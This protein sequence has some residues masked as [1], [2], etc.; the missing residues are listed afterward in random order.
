[1]A[2]HP[3]RNLGLKFA[4]LGLGALLWFTITGERVERKV[5]RVPI[6]YRNLPASLEITD[7]PDSVDIS[8]RGSY[9]DISRL[10]DLAITA[11]LA[12]MVPG[13]NVIPLRVDMVNAPP[14]VEVTQ[15]DPGT[16]TIWL[17][18]SGMAEVPVR[19]TIEGTPA[20]GYAVQRVVVDPRMVVV[21]GPES[22]IKPTTAAVTERV[23]IQGLTETIIQVVNVGVADAQLRLQQPITA[24]V[25]VQIAPAAAELTA[26]DRVVE[27]R[28]LTDGRHID[29]DPPTVTVVV[30]GSGPSAARFDPSAILPWVDVSGRRP[31][32]YNLP[33]RVD[34][35]EAYDVVSITPAT[36]SVRIR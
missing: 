32:R 6:Y 34:H 35:G 24:R 19:P 14:G 7:Q 3:F 30:R 25:T 33:V 2:W 22:R 23:S 26:R 27:W 12:G 28:G 13:A 1:M 17:E 8:V 15:I 9:A 31:G 20:V 4:A 10:Q 18:K 29:E 36:V 21:V 16:V 11:D 5:P